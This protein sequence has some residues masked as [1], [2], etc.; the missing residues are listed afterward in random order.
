[1]RSVACVVTCCG[2]RDSGAAVTRIF[3]RYREALPS[4]ERAQQLGERELEVRRVRDRLRRLSRHELEQAGHQ[5][6]F[7]SPSE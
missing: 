3:N 1:M 2:Q 4:L 7:L 6:A 5:V